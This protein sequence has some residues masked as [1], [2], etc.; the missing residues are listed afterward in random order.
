M[1][2]AKSVEAVADKK[3]LVNTSQGKVL[4]AITGNAF[5]NLCRI[6]GSWISVMI[7]PS[8][9]VRYLDKQT[10]TTWILILQVGVY[11]SIFDNG[12]QSVVGRFV[13][14]AV[15]VKDSDSMRRA[16][17]SAVCILS[18]AALIASLGMLIATWKLKEIFRGI[19]YS[20][21]PSAQ[22]GILIVGLSMAIILPTSTLAGAFLGLQKNKINATAAVAGKLIATVGIAYAAIDHQGIPAMALWF[23][24][25]NLFQGLFF[26]V[27]ASRYKL[28]AFID[29][30]YMS[31]KSI[32]EFM[33]FSYAMFATQM[34]SILIMG[35]DIPI[36]ASFDFHA[37]GYYAIA[38]TSANMLSLPQGAIIGPLIPVAAGMGAVRSEVKMG[39][40]LV[41]VTRYANAVLC[42][43]AFPLIS[44][45]Y[46]I[47]KIWVGNSYASHAYM[48]AVILIVAQFLR[49][50]LLPYAAMGFS[51]GQQH[52]MLVSPMGE[53]VVNLT[54][55]LIGALWLGAIGVALGTLIGAVVGVVL[56][57]VNSMPRTNAIIFP[58]RQLLYEGIF[59]PIACLIIPSIVMAL[60]REMFA[61]VAIQNIILLMAEVLA[62]YLVWQWNF[63]KEERLE[64]TGIFWSKIAARILP[65]SA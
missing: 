61:G 40:S 49:F 15:E 64:I 10:Y 6:G 53:G 26:L 56:H 18:A 54:C 17:S 20:S 7:L 24:A 21:L 1:E 62:V 37:A 55:S 57:F 2:D 5:A 63:T 3:V 59:R 51:V 65:T 42:L 52:K 8:V 58:R 30:A 12:I 43:I 41:R 25:G 48:L 28:Y 27:A 60:G 23:A 29:R 32:H 16:L 34:G 19:T 31:S 13:G 46:L 33:R 22:A 36:V 44:G 35:L 9:L 45:L 50:L 38:A 14:R 39:L 4:S 47:L 11:V